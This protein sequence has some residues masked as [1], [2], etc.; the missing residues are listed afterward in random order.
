MKNN[1]KE[2]NVYT[3]LLSRKE[4]LFV[5]EQNYISL[6]FTEV[7][8]CK[9]IRNEYFYETIFLVTHMILQSCES[10]V[11]LTFHQILS[12]TNVNLISFTTWLQKLQS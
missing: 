8:T 2:A 9:H 11:F 4:Y 5:T 10:A 12:M 6:M 1:N 7:G 3:W